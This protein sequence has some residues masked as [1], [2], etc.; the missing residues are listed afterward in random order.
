MG[1]GNASQRSWHPFA[2]NIAQKGY[3]ALTIDFRGRGNSSG[4]LQIN[5]LIIDARSAIQ[6]LEELGYNHFICIGASMGGTTCMRLALDI[7]LEGMAILSSTLS[8]GR[9]N[10][11]TGD[12]L[13][14][15]EIPK[16][17]IFGDRDYA[18]ISYAMNMA[19][20]SSAQPKELV[21]YDSAAHGTDLFLGPHGDD[22]RQRLIRFIDEIQ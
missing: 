6:F 17:F 10:R 13:S 16:L 4:A 2:R 12:D 11:V 18:D 7:P 14:Q 5:N 1:A 8:L 15:L 3:T 9:D 22:L 20:D 21:V 19:Y